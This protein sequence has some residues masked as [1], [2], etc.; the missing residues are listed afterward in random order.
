MDAEPSLTLLLDRVRDG[1]S[2]A[3]DL[4]VSLVYRELRSMAARRIASERSDHTLQ[5]T[6]LVNEAF[7][8]LF[9]SGPIEWKNRNHFY[10]V[11][12]TVMR[13]ILVDH[14]RKVRGPERGGGRVRVELDEALAYTE[15][16]REDFLG[17]EEAL[18]RLEE[19]SPRAA[20]V[21]VMRFFGGMEMEEIAGE[22][23]V[24][25]RTVK[26][27]W[28]VARTWLYEQ[29]YGKAGPVGSTL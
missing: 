12:A 17:V 21:V 18:Q 6:A 16:I 20:R 29:L 24:T 3:E 27:D 23:G 4:L 13:R 8:K 14:A 19:K 7:I 15:A 1:D 10:A 22:L 2:G 5:P 25:S 28:A 11:A 26:R 9:R